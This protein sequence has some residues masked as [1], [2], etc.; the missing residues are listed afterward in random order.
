[1]SKKKQKEVLPKGAIET[2]MEEDPK[3]TVNE[4]YDFITSHMTPEQALKRL[5]LSTVDQYTQLKLKDGTP[6][7]P[8]FI[9]AACA[10]EIGWQLAV[11]TSKEDPDA[12]LRGLIMGTEEYIDNY[13]K[14]DEVSK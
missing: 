9:A 13:L 5:L 11:E 3:M 1:M 8:Y 14:K 10:L 2:E 6:S 4:L 7:S 12:I